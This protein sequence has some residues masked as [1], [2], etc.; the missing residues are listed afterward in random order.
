MQLFKKSV[1]LGQNF[2]HKMKFALLVLFVLAQA[3]V[4]MTKEELSEYDGRNGTVYLA[5]GG[6]IFDV[7][8]SSS[9]GPKGGYRMFAGKDASVS[10]AMFSFDSK[11]LDMSPE[12]ANLS[13]AHQASIDDWKEFYSENYPIVGELVPTNAKD[14]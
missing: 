14:L 12:E 6:L 4:K 8:S 2:N 5:C 7:T 3:T 1:L 11:Y 13:A 9:Y 10:L